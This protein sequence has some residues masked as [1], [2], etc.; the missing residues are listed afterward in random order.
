[1]ITGDEALNKIEDEFPEI[2]TDLHEEAIEG[3]LHCQIGEFS[4]FA[5]KQIDDNDRETFGRVCR[6]FL[7]LFED[8]DPALEN[9]LN[10]SFL[11][12]LDF[13]DG[14]HARSWGYQ[15][16]PARMRQAFDDMEDYN[17]KIHGG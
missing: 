6:I 10:V 1:M 13:S 3:L 12:H 14:K 11:E 15:F 4:R 5:Q 7:D 8:A 9:A 16:M 2:S 17:R